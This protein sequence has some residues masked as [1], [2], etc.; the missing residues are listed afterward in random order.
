MANIKN[1]RI[2]VERIMTRSPKDVRVERAESADI[3]IRE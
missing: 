2:E 1:S 3:E